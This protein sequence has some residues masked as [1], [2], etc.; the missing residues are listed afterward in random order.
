MDQQIDLVALDAFNARRDR[1]FLGEEHGAVTAAS[2]LD[3]P[4]I[5]GRYYVDVCSR[6]GLLMRY[7]D[8]L[9]VANDPP[10]SGRV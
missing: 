10:L 2:S 3:G 7:G 9:R 5:S 8:N 6:D 1:F 4:F